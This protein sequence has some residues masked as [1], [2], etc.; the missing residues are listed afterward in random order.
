MTG[1]LRKRMLEEE[2][3]RALLEMRVR[4]SV[5]AEIRE[6]FPELSHKPVDNI[7]KSLEGTFLYQQMQIRH[8]VNAIVGMT[9]LPVATRMLAFINRVLQ[10]FSRPSGTDVHKS[11]PDIES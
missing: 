8:N 5:N 2:H 4:N 11:T 7:K 6:L 3:E 9:L 1:N 10:R